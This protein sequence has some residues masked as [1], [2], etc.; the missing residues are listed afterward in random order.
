MSRILLFILKQRST[1]VG[2]WAGCRVKLLPSYGYVMKD[3]FDSSM[4]NVLKDRKNGCEGGGCP[5]AEGW[6]LSS[7]EC[8]PFLEIGS[9]QWW[10]HSGLC[11]LSCLV[12]LKQRNRGEGLQ[13]QERKV[14]IE[15]CGVICYL[16]FPRESIA[17]WTWLV[18]YTITIPLTYFLL[19]EPW[20]TQLHGKLSK[21]DPSF[22]P[23]DNSWL[24]R[25]GNPIP[26]PRYFPSLPVASGE[27]M[28]PWD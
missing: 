6:L 16:H 26:L 4:Q 13:P 14:C 8:L 27:L 22:T 28:T 17:W 25:Y 20:F 10:G 18:A 7:S 21:V 15:S 11:H 5:S 2:F 3:L 23:W 19:S 1:I 9:G 12:L 24:D